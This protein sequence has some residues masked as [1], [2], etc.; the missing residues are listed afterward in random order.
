MGDF[1]FE[2]LDFCR[3]M[4]EDG[5]INS[6]YR[7]RGGIESN[8]WTFEKRFWCIFAGSKSTKKI[9]KE[10]KSG[11]KRLK[12]LYPTVEAVEKKIQEAKEKRRSEEYIKVLENLKKYWQ[13]HKKLWILWENLCRRLGPW[14][15]YKVRPL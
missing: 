15:T 7:E 12:E 5:E 8:W 1:L 2:K 14:K 4:E 6:N 13:K 11:W 3:K 10:T 9:K